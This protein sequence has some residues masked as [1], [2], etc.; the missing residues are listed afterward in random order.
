MMKQTFLC[1]F[2]VLALLAAPAALSLE[3]EVIGGSYGYTFCPVV[4]ETDMAVDRSIVWLK[5]DAENEPV[6][7][8]VMR[9]DGVT[10]FYFI[11]KDL[12]PYE[13]R[14]YEQTAA[15]SEM[16]GGVTIM[17]RDD[18][19][20]I[21]IDGE[22]FTDYLFETSKKQPLQ[23]FYP[24]FGPQGV[25]MTRGYP[26]EKFDGEATDHPHHQSVWVSHGDVNGV[27]FWHLG[28]NQGFQRHQSF[29]F[30][31]S[32]PAAGRF[33]QKIDWENEDGDKIINETRAITIWATP[34]NG[35]IIDFDMSFKAAS[36]DVKFG[37]T[38]EGGLLS[39]RIAHT[40]REKLPNG[41]RGTGVIKNAEGLTGSREA[42]GKASRWCDYSGPV[43][44][45]IAGMTIMDHPSN[46]FYP[47]R[48]HVRDYGL[49]T[50]NPFGLS[51]F[52]GDGHDG[53]SVL[54]AGDEWNLNYRLYIHAGASNE[55]EVDSVYDHFASGPSA[56]VN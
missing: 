52:I 44:G 49:F 47:T 43:G 2:A 28:N 6:A 32:G 25:R 14:V 34:D 8:Q 13:R 19:L 3:I 46:P 50:A 23:I 31:D 37:D 53:T 39:L 24:L 1:L 9:E 33:V 38:K 7:A 29:E 40:M 4:A 27:N 45:V 54:K 30:M 55:A 16:K 20:E 21:A 10:A 36:G 15:P 26:M 51:H 48:Y 22:P 42:W 56:I 41:D 18:K 17:Q 35:R 11:V 5:S 12:K